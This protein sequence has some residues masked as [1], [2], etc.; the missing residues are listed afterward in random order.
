MIKYDGIITVCHVSRAERHA[1]YGLGQYL[2]RFVPAWSTRALKLFFE[3]VLAFHL[4]NAPT[5]R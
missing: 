4:L 5:V 2:T 3:S 1:A